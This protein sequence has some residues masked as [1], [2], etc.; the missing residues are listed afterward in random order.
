ML[1]AARQ[2]KQR[3]QLLSKVTSGKKIQ[4]DGID[5]APTAV[6]KST[7][8][9]GNAALLIQ[10]RCNA[11]HGKTVRDVLGSMVNN[12]RRYS[13]AD[14]RYDIKHGRLAVLAPGKSAGAAPIGKARKEAPHFGKPMPPANLNEF[15]QFLQ[16]QLRMETKEHTGS[17][18][19]FKGKEANTMWPDVQAF[20]APNLG[21]T[22]RWVPYHTILGVH[23]LF[24]VESVHHNAKVQWNEKQRFMA[25]FIFRA[26]CKR[27][28]FTQVQLPL[29]L[30]NRFWRD[31][32]KA[33]QP[34]GLME[35]SI[36]KYRKRTRMPLLTS[37]F[38]N[39]P[40]RILKDNDENLVRSITQRTMK[41]IEV[42]ELSFPI[43]KNKKL[44]PLDKLNQL[45]ALIQDAPGLGETWAKML[46]VCIDLA[47]PKERLLETQCD[48]GTG[49]ATPLKALLPKGGPA[50]KKEA[51][52]ALLHIANKAKNES[53]KHFWSVL[54]AVEA[55]VRTKFKDLPLVCAQANTKQ[56][57][58]SAVTLQVQLCEY[59]QFRH[60]LARLRYGLPD[61][62]TMRCD[63]SETGLRAADF[64]QY[65]KKRGCVKFEFPK[66]VKKIPFEVRVNSVGGSQLVAERVA[67]VCF[68]KFVDGWHKE[69]AI[70]LR[71]D[72][73]KGYR[74]G[75]DVK[76]DSEAWD[77]CKGIF[78]TSKPSDV[79]AFDFFDKTG[80]KLHFQ[81]TQLASGGNLLDAE[82]I[83]RLCW[84]KLA[85]G[86]KKEAVMEYRNQIYKKMAGAVPP[87][88]KKLRKN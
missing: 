65:D 77:I 9:A 59:R 14:L 84:A 16:C 34:D 11:C 67:A 68:K 39:I 21:Q 12:G 51:L 31:P 28:L 40:E 45:S 83:A 79:V 60:S 87:P 78:G 69:D 17:D 76:E 62:E 18:V 61:D 10:E 27:D 56:G 19:E 73:V 1:D 41:L 53:A 22:E 29:M 15:F 70:K 24:L 88:Q 25:M 30:N 86:T 54:R 71:D 4:K 36:L 66:G 64:V 5:L 80:K 2:R 3:R 20:V 74:G 63:A 85:T 6:L 48:V 52:K 7:E 42:A 72:M 37:C 75:D 81:T 82:R 44:K 47:Y 33:F 55:Q 8:K 46:T 57:N 35:K 49:A 43:V 23:E 26:H 38:R 50:D 13:M 32:V 58:M